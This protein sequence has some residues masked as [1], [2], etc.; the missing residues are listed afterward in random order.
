MAIIE[1]SALR[2]SLAGAAA[3]GLDAVPAGRLAERLRREPAYRRAR[4]VFA[5]PAPILAQIRVNTLLDNKTLIMPSAGLKEGFFRI[6]PFT[7]P[8]P[9]LAQAVTLRGLAQY[10]ERLRGE[11][12]AGLA[13]DLMVTDALA[14]D[15]AGTLVGDGHGF[16]DLAV[17]LLGAHGALGEE[18]AIF[19]VPGPGQMLDERIAA[20]PWDVQVD[21]AILADQVVTFSDRPPGIPAIQWEVLP[22]DK[23]RRIDPLWKLYEKKQGI[24]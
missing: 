4:Q 2:S 11:A 13:I 23:V 1:K 12:L 14:V 8:F 7:V 6:R 5:S 24:R 16:F 9:E 19:V 22:L 10:G 20:D 21:A 17:A 18:V 3:A 15:E